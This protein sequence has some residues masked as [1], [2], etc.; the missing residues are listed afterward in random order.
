MKWILGLLLA[1]LAASSGAQSVYKCRDAKGQPVY[2]SEPCPEAE[3]RWDT[4]PS[5]TTWDDYY[6]RQEADR[7]I[8]ADRQHMRARARE[9]SNGQGPSGASVGT[10]NADACARAK[11]ARAQAYEAMGV[12]R[13]FQASRHW[14]DVVW[15]A[16][17]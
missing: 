3:K 17:K 12:S 10:P 1:G 8:A 11:A 13:N 6:K 16:C 2:Q 7:K 14:D 9:L 4:Q 5:T 15:N